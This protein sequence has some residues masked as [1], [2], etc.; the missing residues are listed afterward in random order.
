MPTLVHKSAP[1][2]TPVP[3]PSGTHATQPGQ[4]TTSTQPGGIRPRKPILAATGATASRPAAARHLSDEQVYQL[5]VELDTLR[6][7][8]IAT[9]GAKDAAYIRRVI[10]AQRTLEVA[11]RATLMLSKKKTA[12]VAGTAML[13]VA[14]ILENMEIGHNVLHGQWDWMRDPDIHS[15]TWEWDFVTPAAAWKHTHNDLHHTW[16]NVLGKDKD[17]G[18]S[19]L[20][21]AE[22]QPW[23]PFNILNP[24]INAV[25]APFFEWG[26]AI[27]DLELEAVKEGEKSKDDLKRDLKAVG[28]KVVRQFTKDYVATPAAAAVFGSGKQALIGT[29]AA[30][31][32]RNVWA[33]SVIFCGHF[34]DG[35]DV[36]S[37]DEIEGETRGDWYI[38]QMLGSANISGSKT[39]HLMTGNL[40]HQIEHHCFP[41]LP[42]N[43]YHEVAV[44]MRE[45]T[46][47]YGLPYT[48]GPIH[49]QVGQ[50]WA[51][52]FRLALPPK[53][54]RT[55]PTEPD[56]APTSQRSPLPMVASGL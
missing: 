44:H 36:F 29:F 33:H 49:R 24:A 22:D 39:M 23:K 48:T 31:A 26:I 5:G 25:L 16:T 1:T 10:R 51:K 13:S 40:S 21:M 45:I 52:V 14:K 27:Y 35:V 2:P 3:S 18:Y 42:S 30:N 19:T 50:A 6:D 38:R 53:K 47:R 4:P 20:R 43:R 11:G 9:R 7:S 41:D 46:E 56:A 12:L 55:A 34:P 54:S 8:I 17:V 15:T 32:I 28:R 37:E